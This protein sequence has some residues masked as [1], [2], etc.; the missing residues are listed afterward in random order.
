M[1]KGGSEDV[2]VSQ[3]PSSA[4]IYGAEP[5]L[6]ETR[7]P[8]EGEL[9]MAGGSDGTYQLPNI[10][11]AL[12]FCSRSLPKRGIAGIVISRKQERVSGGVAESHMAL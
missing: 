1:W 6:A 7:G 12:Q 10:L 3:K 4:C 5:C 11:H 9:D 8:R 2:H